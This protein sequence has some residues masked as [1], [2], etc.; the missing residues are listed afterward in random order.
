VSI[1]LSSLSTVEPPNS[2]EFFNSS[3][4]IDVDV[5]IFLVLFGL[6]HPSVLSFRLLCVISFVIVSGLSFVVF[7]RLTFHRSFLFCKRLTVLGRNLFVNCDFARTILPHE[8]T[9][10]LAQFKFTTIN[11]HFVSG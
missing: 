3:F 2:Y 1:S 5:F 4:S 8:F 9:F 11:P 10:V 6:C 7:V